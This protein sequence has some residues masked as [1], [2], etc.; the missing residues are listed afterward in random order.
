[1]RQLLEWN[2]TAAR[3]AIHLPTATAVVAD[4]HLDYAETRRRRGDAIPIPPLSQVL[5]P[6][7]WAIRRHRVHR[8][9]VAGDLFEA[10]FQLDSA[11]AFRRWVDEQGIEFLG[12]VPGNHDRGLDDGQGILPV[13]KEQV[14]VGGWSIIHGDTTE[15]GCKRVQGHIHPSLRLPTQGVAAPCFLVSDE[16]IVLPAFSA[17]AAGV[18]VLGHDEWRH[19]RC[20][21]IVGSEV[22]DFGRVAD[23][24]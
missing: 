24:R 5:A 22:L 8:L 17:D 1:M 2:L 12:I 15:T 19:C 11:R 18:N 3:A 13:C 4:L 21:V 10:G 9:I 20:L 6:L 7:E 16:Q 14:C 23:L